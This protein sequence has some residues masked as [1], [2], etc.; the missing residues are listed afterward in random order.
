MNLL[1]PRGAVIKRTPVYDMI[2]TRCASLL[3][4]SCIMWMTYDG[5]GGSDAAQTAPIWVPIER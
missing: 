4:P 1:L 2:R 3:R 5:L